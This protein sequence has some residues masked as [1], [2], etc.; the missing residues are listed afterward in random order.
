MTIEFRPHATLSMISLP[1]TL[2]SV[3]RCQSVRIDREQEQQ[4]QHV[5]F[6]NSSAHANGAKASIKAKYTIATQAGRQA[7]TKQTNKTS[8]ENKT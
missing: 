1:L 7:H 3:E 2:L 8:N 4:Q 5:A 6:Y